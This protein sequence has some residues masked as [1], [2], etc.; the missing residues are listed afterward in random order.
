MSIRETRL[1]LFPLMCGLIAIVVARPTRADLV[2]AAG[3]EV[4]GNY[5]I[6]ANVVNQGLLAGLDPTQRVTVAEGFTISGVGS[7]EN[8]TILG[9]YAPGNSAAIIHGTNQQI[10]GVVE[11]ELGGIAPGFG[12]NNHDQV[13]DSVTL[14][15]L[16]TSTLSILP[17]NSFVPAEGDSFTVFTWQ[18]QLLGSP[19]TVTVD[20]FFANNGVTFKIDIINPTG[21][22]SLVLIAVPEAGQ[23]V[24]GTLVCTLLGLRRSR[25][26]Q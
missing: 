26:G 14:E 5:E 3:E 8:T 22:G 7:L 17:L 19:G 13:N 23:L 18:T 12:A 9:T 20:P 16:P 4:R 11:I 15:F 6:S 25:R 2:I 1:G 24:C 10:G 21:P